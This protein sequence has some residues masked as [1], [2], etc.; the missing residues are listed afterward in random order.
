MIINADLHIHSKYSMATSKNMTV[1]TIAAQCQKKG[2]DLIATGDAFHSGWLTHLEESLTQIGNTGIY[3][4]KQS[5]EESSTNFITTVEVEDNRRIHHLIII[6]SIDVA[7]SMRD[8]FVTK[9][10]D[11]DGRPKIRMNPS[12][13]LEIAHE[14]NCIIGPA[15]VFTPWTGLYKEYDSITDCYN[16]RA[17]FVELGLSADTYLADRIKELNGYTFLTNS[18]SH[19]PWPHRIAREFNRIELDELSYESLAD[20]IKNNHVIGNYGLDP[21]MGKYHETGCI[22]CY[23]IYSLEEASRLNMKCSCGGRI[24][25]GVLGRITELSNYDVPHHPDG[26]PP[27]TYI[28]PLAELLSAIYDKGVTTKFV[29]LRYEK[30][31]ELFG[32]E[33]DILTRVDIDEISSHDKLLA[34][35]I[36]IYRNN[37]LNVIVGRG[38][39]YGQ[40]DYEIG[41]M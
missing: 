26:R 10:M 35:V 25:K 37:E 30:L 19:S 28:L 2:I 18:D 8:E 33:I 16:A 4:S 39:L 40:V 27:Y 29:Q 31:L 13:I 11:A 12:H 36:K 24:K 22:S 23:K 32:S 15:H 6:P 7:W 14:Y 41:G 34:R 38:G 1:P 20:A 3:T 5:V 21:R 9:D 17:D